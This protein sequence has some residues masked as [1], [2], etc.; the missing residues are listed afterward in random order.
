[1]CGVFIFTALKYGVVG[2]KKWIKLPHCVECGI[3]TNFS[4]NDNN[5]IG[6]KN[7]II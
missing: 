5:Y 7:C 3:R 4:N 1:M 6:F 2:R